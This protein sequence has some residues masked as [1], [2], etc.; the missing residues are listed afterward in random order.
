MIQP[1]ILVCPPSHQTRANNTFNY[2]D[3]PVELDRCEILV[4][5][6][7]LFQRL[8]ILHLVRVNTASLLEMT[9]LNFMLI[10]LSVI[11]IKLPLI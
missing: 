7:H 6:T 1:I 8:L 4:S 5:Y 11:L 2:C 9:K 10:K 3:W